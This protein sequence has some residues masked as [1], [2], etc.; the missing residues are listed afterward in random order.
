MDW[1]I[2]QIPQRKPPE[3]QK[4]AFKYIYRFFCNFYDINYV[5]TSEHEIRESL[6]TIFHQTTA[7]MSQQE[8]SMKGQIVCLLPELV[9]NLQK[10]LYFNAPEKTVTLAKHEVTVYS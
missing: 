4:L 6:Y 8:K 9:S 1:H 3:I 10:E 7:I 2:E 5:F